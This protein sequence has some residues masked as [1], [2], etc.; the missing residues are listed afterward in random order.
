M[1]THC[2]WLRCSQKMQLITTVKLR[3]MLAWSQAQLHLTWKVNWVSFAHVK[4]RNPCRNVK[5]Q[6]MYCLCTVSE[7]V[8]P[9]TGAPMTPPVVVSPISN[10]STKEGESARFQCR[11]SGEGTWPWINILCQKHNDDDVF[12]NSQSN[13]FEH[14]LKWHHFQMWRSAGSVVRRRSN[15]LTSSGCLSLVT[16]AN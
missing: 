16:P 4:Y 2:Y 15:S 11:V 10:A 8:S 1:S 6:N 13:C 9:D 3:M 7:V 12:T 5:I 14:V